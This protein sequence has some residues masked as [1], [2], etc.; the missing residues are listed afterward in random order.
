[1][2]TSATMRGAMLALVLTSACAHGAASTTCREGRSVTLYFGRDS[3]SGLVSEADFAA[4]EADTIAPALPDGYTRFEASGRYRDPSGRD[5]LEPSF[6]IVVVFASAEDA[7]RASARI[8]D[9]RLAYCA[10]FAQ[11][12]V[13]R[14]DED[15]SVS[16]DP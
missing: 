16:F 10:R 8:D 13:L 5:V 7:R 6:V 3:P 2:T 4:F 1:M 15:V 12:S 14:V 11:T 9:V